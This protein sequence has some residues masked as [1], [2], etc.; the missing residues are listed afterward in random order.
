MSAVPESEGAMTNWANTR[1]PE[2]EP[3]TYQSDRLDAPF[4]DQVMDGQ[5]ADQERQGAQIERVDIDV[6]E[7]W[8]PGILAPTES[9][10]VSG[11]KLD[12]GLRRADA[13]NRGLLTPN[14]Q[15]GLVPVRGF[16]P[17]FDG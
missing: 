8:H 4:R 16:E 5:R 15:L 6:L 3:T 13:L 9:R 12:A 17:R 1:V 11:E 2:K 7:R 10:I 14:F